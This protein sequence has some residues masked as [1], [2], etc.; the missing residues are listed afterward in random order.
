MSEKIDELNKK[1]RDIETDTIE[2]LKPL[3]LEERKSEKGSYGSYQ[4]FQSECMKK[5]DEN[6]PNSISRIE[7]ITGKKGL[8]STERMAKCSS[9]WKKHRG[10]KDPINSLLDE[11]DTAERGKI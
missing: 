10:D 8:H 6:N 5:V 3:R 11:L 2:I 7:V 4:H 9:L 1:I